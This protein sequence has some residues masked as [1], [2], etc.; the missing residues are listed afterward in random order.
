MCQ[1]LLFARTH[2]VS[3]TLLCSWVMIKAC[4]R[5][6]R[7]KKNPECSPARISPAN[8]ELPL[9]ISI[10]LLWARRSVIP[11]A[12]IVFPPS[13][14]NTNLHRCALL[15]PRGPRRRRRR[16]HAEQILSNIY[17]FALFHSPMCSSLDPLGRVNPLWSAIKRKRFQ[18]IQFLKLQ[19][20]RKSYRKLLQKLGS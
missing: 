20:G 8:I 17:Q 11:E 14:T 6:L 9:K 13:E 7:T 12:R 15:S 10:N 16:A 5:R 18:S 2:A 3:L 1:C 4:A 19:A